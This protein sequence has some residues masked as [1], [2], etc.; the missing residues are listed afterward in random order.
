MI[1]SSADKE[2]CTVIMKKIDCPKTKPHDRGRN[3]A[4]KEHRNRLYNM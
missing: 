3:T 1:I 2:S 4:R